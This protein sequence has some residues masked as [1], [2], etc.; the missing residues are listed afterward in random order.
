MKRMWLKEIRES[1]NLTHEQVAKKAGIVRAY[2]TQIENGDRDPS[3]KVAK[4][5]G[6]ALDFDWVLFFENESGESPQKSTA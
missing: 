3:V 5:I 1:Q 4:S 6:S 2:Y